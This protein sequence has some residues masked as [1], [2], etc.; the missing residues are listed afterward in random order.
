MILHVNKLL[1]RFFYTMFQLLISTERV[2][3]DSF[4]TVKD[5]LTWKSAD[6]DCES[7]YVCRFC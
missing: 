2:V 5:E 4:V 3:G 1:K 6:L 7:R